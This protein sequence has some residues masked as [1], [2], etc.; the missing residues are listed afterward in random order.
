MFGANCGESCVA[1]KLFVKMLLGEIQKVEQTTYPIEC[2]SKIIHEKFVVSEIP[3][4]MKMLAFLAGELT[5]SA[6]YFSTF[7]KCQHRHLSKL[8]RNLWLGV[9]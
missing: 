8:Q 4:D 7:A 1:V 9:L 6:K 5:N 3:N 2:K